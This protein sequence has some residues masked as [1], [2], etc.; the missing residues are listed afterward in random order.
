[1]ETIIMRSV[2]ML[3]ILINK[4]KLLKKLLT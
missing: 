3:R 1:M 2:R 4:K